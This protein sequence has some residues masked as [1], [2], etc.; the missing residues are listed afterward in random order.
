M[1]EY[2]PAALE[3]FDDWTAEGPWAFVQAFPTP[4]K[5]IHAGKRRWEKFLHAH[6]LYR[7]E[8]YPR[9]LEIFARADKFAGPPAVTHAKSRL[10]V[11][12]VK[13]LR[14]LQAQLRDYRTTI[15]KL[16]AEH[17]DRDVFGSLPGAGPKLAPRLLS[18]LGQDRQRFQDPQALQCYSGT[19]PLTVQSGKN[20]WVKFRRACNKSLRSAVHH[21]ANL[22]RAECAWAQ[23][24]YK[25]KR[26]QGLSHSC[27]LRCLGQRWL[28]ILWKMWQTGTPYDEALHTLNQVKHGSWVV[29]LT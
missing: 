1:H 26:D 22:S 9:R 8:T 23:A 29:T 7:A 14:V 12:L 3:A 13:Q 16:F 27:A 19:A 21:W 20:R 10:A 17:P 24:Y 15:E 6:K 11:A 5:L 25:H 4:A 2:Y 18:E 28:K